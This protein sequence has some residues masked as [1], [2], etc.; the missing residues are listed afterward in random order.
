VTG[1]TLDT[2]ALIALERRHA[3]I[4]RVVRAAAQTGMRI[5][6]PVAV[7]AEWWRGSS[8][9]RELIRASLD[10]EPMDEDLAKSAGEALAVVKRASVVD[11]ILMASAARRGDI[12]Y[13]RDYEDLERLRA[14]FRA[15]P[16]VLTA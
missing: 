14:H 5:T 9:I 13:T 10:I 8:R 16:R 3:R 7:V 4:S 6:V 11:A 12:V 15:V 1:L 2:G